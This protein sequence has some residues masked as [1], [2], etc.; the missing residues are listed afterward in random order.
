VSDPRP[1]KKPFFSGLAGAITGV[2]GLLSAVAALT[3]LAVNQGWIGHSS[4]TGTVG[5][6]AAAPGAPSAD[7]T[8]PQFTVNPARVN[9]ESL[10][11][12]D[13]TV[14]VQNTGIAKFTVKPPTLT[15][16]NASLFDASTNTCSGSVGAGRSCDL[17]V[18]FKSKTGTFTATLVVEVDGAPR[19]AE[20]PIRAQALL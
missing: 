20:V 12:R 1:H 4:K 8:T 13:A 15:G 17:K 14:T 7:D 19:A 18:T 5:A 3:G 10:G 9:F 16:P 6:N 2:A 11:A